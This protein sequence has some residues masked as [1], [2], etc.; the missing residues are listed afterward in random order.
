MRLVQPWWQLA[1]VR[2]Y[3]FPPPSHS[4]G[5]S[6]FLVI[7]AMADTQQA[8]SASPMP[9]GITDPNYKPPPGRLGNLTVPQ[10]HAL[11][12]LKKQLKDEGHF[13]EER[14]DDATL[15]RSAGSRYLTVIAFDPNTAPPGRF[16]RARKFDLAKAKDMLLSAERW[17]DE[18]GVDEIMKCVLSS[19]RF[20]ASF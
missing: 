12:T 14:M 15:L 4:T 2:T 11:D 10:Q 9:P 20:P 13:V 1:I 17:R 7:V 5:N 6:H 19:E 18:F 3:T 8:A 16:L